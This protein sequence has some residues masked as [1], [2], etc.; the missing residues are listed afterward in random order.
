M[1][2]TID[3]NKFIFRCLKTLAFPLSQYSI[4]INLLRIIP[5]ILL[6]FSEKKKLMSSRKSPKDLLV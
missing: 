3:C 1:S 2:C 4:F 6:G 5:H